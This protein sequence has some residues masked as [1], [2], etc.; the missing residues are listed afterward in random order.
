[1]ARRQIRRRSRGQIIRRQFENKPKRKFN[2]RKRRVFY[3]ALL[4]RL[5]LTRCAELA[6]ITFQTYRN[7]MKKGQNIR[8]PVHRRFRYKVKQII[9]QN[10]TEA[11]EIIRRA[12]GGGAQVVETKIVVGYKGTETTRTVKKALP[13]WQAAAWYLE[14]RHREDYG[15]EAIPE[16]MRKSAEEQAAEV[17]QALEVLYRSVPLGDE[18]AQLPDDMPT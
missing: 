7:W 18:D 1:M 15:R 8:H 3:K 5:P 16:D 14:R 9:A 17:K 13:T 10:E 2:A 11:L 6:G 12:A 4:Q